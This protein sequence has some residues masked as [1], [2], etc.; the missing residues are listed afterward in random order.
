MEPRRIMIRRAAGPIPS[1]L[2]CA[3]LLSCALILAGCGSHDVPAGNQTG[4]VKVEGSPIKSSG[5]TGLPGTPMAQRSAVIGL[6]NK[7]NG[8][9]RDLTMKPGEALRVGD[10]IVR[11]QA[12]ETTAP[13]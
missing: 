2:R 12:C 5:A 4:P 1:I 7:R 9:T 13:W 8:L 6:L 11:L 3:P 10:A